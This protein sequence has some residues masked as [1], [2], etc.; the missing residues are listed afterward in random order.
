[1]PKIS[2]TKEIELELLKLTR[3]HIRTRL[4]SHNGLHWVC[5]LLMG[6]CWLKRAFLIVYYIYWH[7]M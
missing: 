5:E 1:V 3:W 2:Q 6:L 7:E 4:P